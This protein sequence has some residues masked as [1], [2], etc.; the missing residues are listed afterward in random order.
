MSKNTRLPMMCV[1]GEATGYRTWERGL[2]DY[3]DNTYGKVDD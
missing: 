1:H 3:V 2:G